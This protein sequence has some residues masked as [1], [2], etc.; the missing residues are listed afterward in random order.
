[1]AD[2]EVAIALGA[3]RV[4]NVKYGR[5]GGLLEARRIASACIRAGIAV[6][7]GGMLETGVG[8]AHNLALNSLIE[9]SLPGDI[10]ASDR[11]WEQDIVEPRI[12]MEGGMIELSQEPGMG[13]E[14]IEERVERFRVEQEV[15]KA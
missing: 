15:V 7:C 11:Y 2:V 12:V 13:Y 1:M 4:V 5:V 3:C 9:F 10:S 8:R 6:W 14:V